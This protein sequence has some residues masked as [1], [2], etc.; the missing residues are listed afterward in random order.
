MSQITRTPG[1]CGGKPCIAGH[2]VRVSDIVIW[3]EHE[4][5]SADAIVSQ[6]PGLSLADVYTALAY[7]YEHLEEIRTEIRSESAAVEQYRAR[8]DSLLVERINHAKRVS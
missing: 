7:Y 5:L 8:S 3:H 2:R 1:V 6:L 4:G